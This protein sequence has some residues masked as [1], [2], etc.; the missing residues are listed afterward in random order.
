MRTKSLNCYKSDIIHM[1]FLMQNVDKEIWLHY[2]NCYKLAKKIC[3]SHDE[4]SDIASESIYRLLSILNS[5]NP[6]DIQNNLEAYLYKIV[7]NMCMDILRKCKN[8]ISLEELKYHEYYHLNYD[9]TDLYKVIDTYPKDVYKLIIMKLDGYS[10]KECAN[11]FNTNELA[12]KVKW[13]RIKNKIKS[14]FE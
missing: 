9:L 1:E 12:I 10:T 11:D 2:Q 6:P 5:E 13:H 7:I 4:A 14:E 3:K 8:R